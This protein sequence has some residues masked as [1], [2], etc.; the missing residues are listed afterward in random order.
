MHFIETLRSARKLELFILLAVTAILLV[1]A[2][3]GGGDG[4]QTQ[5]EAEARLA[6]LLSKIEGAGKVS[7]ML[8]QDGD[9]SC[10]GAVIATE[11]ADEIG[12]VL[13]L[14]RA[15]QT[16]T[17]LELDRIEIVRAGR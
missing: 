1:L 17:G 5:T 9:G 11:A 10:S 13:Q 12:V 8:R 15:V 4:A 7:V 3:G 16:L 6:G 14:E 2:L